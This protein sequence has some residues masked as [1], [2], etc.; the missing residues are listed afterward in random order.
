MR[1]E[2]LMGCNAENVTD[3]LQPL[4]ACHPEP[5]RRCAPQGRLREG[6]ESRG[7]VK[8][9]EAPSEAE[10][11]GS[12][13]NDCCFFRLDPSLRSEAVNFLI[14][15]LDLGQSGALRG[16][17]NR[18]RLRWREAIRDVS[19]S[20]AAARFAQH[21]IKSRRTQKF[22][23]LSDDRFNASGSSIKHAQGRVAGGFS[24]FP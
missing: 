3:P 17:Q 21:D 15:R 24:L 14:S 16:L 13:R 5:I 11:E 22:H 23:T 19:T 18:N 6:T 20:F 9:A 1:R 4:L 10:V 8:P 7:R 2:T 12:T